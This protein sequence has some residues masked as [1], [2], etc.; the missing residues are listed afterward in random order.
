M[1]Q[2]TDYL[3]LEVSG[4]RAHHVIAFARR[5]G[6]RWLV[7][8]GTRLFASLGLLVDT[9]SGARHGLEGAAL[10]LARV[11]RDFPVAALSGEAGA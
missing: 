8:I 5:D 1:L 9:I 11:L 2:H 3:P 4:E 10:P 6:P 7:V